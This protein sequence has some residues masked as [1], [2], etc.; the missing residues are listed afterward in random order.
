VHTCAH[1]FNSTA[2]EAHTNG[3][4]NGL[5]WELRKKSCNCTPQAQQQSGSSIPRAA[6][7]DAAAA[8]AVSA[9]VQRL[10]AMRDTWS[11]DHT[12]Y[13]KQ[14]PEITTLMNDFLSA[15]LLQKPADVY[16][17]ARA[18]FSGGPVAESAA[19]SCTDIDA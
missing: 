15:V 18:Y 2:E 11:N 19:P 13:L 8:A 1:V 4:F 6:M 3:Y 14:H 7:P 16:A 5:F 12:A 17:F 10:N 9:D